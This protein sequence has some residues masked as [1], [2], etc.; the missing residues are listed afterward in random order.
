MIRRLGALGAVMALSTTLL[1]AQPALAADAV[2]A[3]VP[4]GQFSGGAL[5]T[6]QTNGTVWALGSSQGK[7]FAGGTFTAVRAPGTAEGDA[8]SLTRT[9]LVILDAASGVPSTTCNLPVTRG[10]SSAQV[11][12]IAA[13]P[14]GLT[15]YIGGLFTTIGGVA[16]NNLAAVNVATCTVTAFNP[17]PSSFVYGITATANTVYFGGLFNAVGGQARTNLGAA[18]VAGVVTPWAPQ[19]DDEMFA[20]A[21]DPHNGNVIIGGRMNSVNNQDSHALAIVD[22]TTGTTNVK[23][24][25]AGFYD[26]SPGLGQRNGTSVVKTLAVDQNGFYV[27]NE[28][29]GGG[30]FDGRTAFNWDYTQRWRDTC[31]GA[32]QAVIPYNGILFWASHS[33]DCGSVGTWEDGQRHFFGSETTSDMTLQPWL[34]NA[35]D[36]IGEGIG[37]RALTIASTTSGAAY[38]WAGGE[39]TQINGVNQRGLTRFGN[40]DNTVPTTPPT[41]IAMSTGPGKVTVTWRATLDLDSK[42]LL[43]KVYRNGSTTALATVNADGLFFSRGQGSFVDTSVVTGQSYTYRVTASDGTNTS[44]L[45]AAS[46]SV[47]VPATNLA[48]AN[49]VQSDGASVYFREDEPSG[50]SAASLGSSAAGGAY[51]GTPARSGAGALLTDTDTSVAFDGTVAAPAYLHT[52]LRQPGPTTYSIETWF[53]TTSTVGG[54]LVGFGDKADMNQVNNLSGNYDRHI[55]MTNNGQLIF[56]VYTGGTQTVASAAGFNDGQWHQV[57]ATQGSAG[58]ALYVDGVRVGRN[59]VTGNQ[60]YTGY[61]RVG[62]DN[63]G[64]WPSQPTFSSGAASNFFTGSMDETAIYPTALTGAQIANHFNLSGRTNAAVPPV[65]TDNYGKAVYQ[66]GPDLYWR[67]GESSG[68]TA[69]DA[70]GNSDSGTFGSGVTL[71]GPSAVSGTANTS[72]TLDG[73]GNGL[74]SEATQ[75]G[76]PTVFTTEAWFKTSSTTGGEIIG[77]GDQPTGGSSSYD[78]HTYLDNSGHLNFGV[79]NNTT[80]VI[81]SPNTYNDNNWHQVDSVQDANGMR[82]Y[83]DGV[84]VNS[85]TIAQNQTYNG[86][87]RVGGNTLNGWPNQP[88]NFSFTGSVDEVAVYSKA[89]TSAQISSH[90]ALGTGGT[91]LDTTAPSAPTALAATVSGQSVGLSWT[92]STDN[93]AVTKY[94]VYRSSTSG[95]TPSAATNVGTV[96]SGTTY[97]DAAPGVGTWYY[98]VTASDAAGNESAASTQA[99]ATVLDTTAPS[100]P[101]ALAATVSGQSVGLSWTGS[102][103]NVAVTKY[104]VYRSS[105]SGFTPSA[106]TNVGTVTSGTTYTDAAPGVGTWYYVVTASDAAGNESAA[107]TQASATVLD[108]TAPSAPTGLIATTSGANIGLSWT[109]STDNVA[110]TTYTVYKSATGGF[111]PSGATQIGTVPAGTTTYSDAGPGVGTWYYVVTASDAA[112]N[113]SAG[114]SQASATIA[115]PDTTA[116]TSPSGLTATVSGASIGLSWTGSTDNVGVTNY[117]V[118]RSSTTGF[119]PSAAT[120]L[121]TVTSATTYTDAAPGAGTWYYVVT[122]SDA[123]GNESAGSSQAS[124]TIAAPDTTAPTSPSGLTATVSGASIGLS[125]TGSTDNVAVTKYT[126]YRSSTTGFTPS[127]ATKLGTVTS[128]TT[129]TDAA[130]GVGTWYYLVTA[131]DAAGNESAASNQASAIIAASGTQTVSLAPAEDAYGVQAAPTTNY[132][133]AA[134]LAVRGGSSSFASYLKFTVP[135]AP[136][137]KSLVSASL[138]FTTDSDTF[139]GTLD[140]VAV[141]VAPS[142]WAETT[143]TWA[144]RPTVGAQL[145]T[146]GTAA[147]PNSRYSVSL[148]ASVLATQPSGSVTLAMTDPGTDNLWIWSRSYSVASARPTLTLVYQ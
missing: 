22:G 148:N 35:N 140:T 63:L 18:S 69:V 106:A 54:K 93:V 111:T 65:P 136:A 138:A 12:A 130:P 46:T 100:A 107:S 101:T 90:Y 31:L 147:N 91:P 74:I 66:D 95:F 42:T 9:N 29:T 49:A 110:V 60:S 114:S 47:K 33:H 38:L 20:L 21:V 14:D 2:L 113:E 141:A 86:F 105:T 19:V 7:V 84:M 26:W 119:T 120:K 23:N 96:T 44:A 103:D 116:P 133:T 126:V 48:Y 39:F 79:Y 76:S 139:S 78:K 59:S 129:Y 27:G 98:V 4:A 117:T 70:T 45:S 57:V 28:G 88:A 15:M 99:S 61:W 43:Y 41:P 80:T 17:S 6:W 50:V 121:G 122:A 87:W 135:A 16:R 143:L 58:M 67:L 8:S 53:K 52:E 125:W 89:L 37:P 142:T 115:A 32:T 51:F 145:G 73:T 40:A 109:G 81:T 82:L 92:G 104:T 134:T 112:G 83:V 94:T 146:I 11:R 71:G 68:T 64:G 75:S 1:V 97:T 30:I 118:Y 13:S 102:T 123:A 72:V 36:G 85:N 62:G 3:P 137:G 108:T 132:G 77:Y 124:A 128:A 25:P 55:Y 131:S 127:A 5:P 24:Y 10:S 34:P 56:G 144:N